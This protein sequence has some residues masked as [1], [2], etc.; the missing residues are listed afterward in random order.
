MAININ[1]NAQNAITRAESHKK[2][3]KI[4][5]KKGNCVSCGL[6]CIDYC[7]S[8]QQ[9]TR[10]PEGSM[11]KRDEEAEEEEEEIDCGKLKVEYY[12]IVKSMQ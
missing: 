1:R 8:E 11:E 2:Q 3:R 9:R 12:F 4:N 5:G 10:E 6:Q 7:Q